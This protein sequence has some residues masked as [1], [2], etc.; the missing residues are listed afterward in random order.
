M[1]QLLLTEWEM[2][3]ICK[4]GVPSRVPPNSSLLFEV[5]VLRV[6]TPAKLLIKSYKWWKYILL[7]VML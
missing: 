3:C 5:E 7:C 6:S 1:I 2:L 4:Q